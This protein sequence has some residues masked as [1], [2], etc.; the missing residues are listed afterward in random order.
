VTTWTLTIFH[1]KTI[2]GDYFD[3]RMTH[4]RSSAYGWW[5]TNEDDRY[6][7]VRYSPGDWYICLYPQIECDFLKVRKEE[8]RIEFSG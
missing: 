7:W 3:Y 2:D 4:D 1:Y 5:V 6:Y 8:V